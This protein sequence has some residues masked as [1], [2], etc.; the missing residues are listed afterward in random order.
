MFTVRQEKK[1]KTKTKNK[2]K[3]N[4]TKQKQNKEMKISIHWKFVDFKAALDTTCREAL[5]KS[6]RSVGVD[7]KPVNLIE[8]MYEDTKCYFVVHGNLSEWFEVLVGVRQ[9]SLCP[10]ASSTCIWS[11]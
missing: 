11:L 10:L 8:R 1:T 9:G 7:P 5:W 4:K 2:T 3:Q 6:L